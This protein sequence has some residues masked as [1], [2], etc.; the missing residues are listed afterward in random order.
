MPHERWCKNSKPNFYKLNLTLPQ[1]CMQVQAAI[2][3]WKSLN[4][5]LEAFVITSSMYPAGSPQEPTCTLHE[6]GT[7]PIWFTVVFYSP[8]QGLVYKKESINIP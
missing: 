6:A 5:L 1:E 7:V 2:F 3:S 8:A 4:P